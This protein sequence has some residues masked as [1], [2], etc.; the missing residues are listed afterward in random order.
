MIY[1]YKAPEK[2]PLKQILSPAK[3]IFLAG[4]IELGTASE[5]QTQVVEELS[6]QE[7]D[8]I[9]FN[10]RRDNWDNNISEEGFAE[11]VNWELDH[12]E[13]ADIK[14][15]YFDPNTKS[16]VT[17]L[18]LGLML[19]RYHNQC[20]VC[21][22]PGFWRRGNLEITCQRCGVKLLDNFEEFI[23]AIVLKL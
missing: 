8:A 17:M 23:E 10:P 2:V 9:I 4:S 16:P 5:W 13:Q 15:F 19:A 12:I 11:Q 20:V 18:E 7:K 21:S 6:K 3:T 22:P 1:H 14:A